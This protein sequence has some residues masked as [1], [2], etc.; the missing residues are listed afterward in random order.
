M[1][2]MV[3]EKPLAAQ[4]QHGGSPFERDQIEAEKVKTAEKKRQ[5]RESSKKADEERVKLLTKRLI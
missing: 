1:W 3:V 5:K 2:M 4:Q